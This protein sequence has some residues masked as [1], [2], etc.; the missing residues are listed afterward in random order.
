MRLSATSTPTPSKVASYWGEGIWDELAGRV[1]LDFGCRCGADAIEAARHGAAQ[2]IGLD[3]VPAALAAAANAAARAGVA[4]VCTFATTTDATADRILCIDAFE[5]FAD[6]AAILRTMDGLLRPGGVVLV[7]FG[8]PW[9]HP[10]GGHAFSVFPWA[11]L[12]FTERALCRWR[13]DY[14]D[15]GAT[16]FGE[17]EGGL[18]RMTICRF[19]RLVADSPFRLAA[20]EA[21]PI[22]PLRW[23]H[24]RL[25]REFFTS[26]VRCRLVRRS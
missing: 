18:N 4:D 5:H 7:T 13:G 15:D 16:R 23:L 25:S 20:F 21:V 24:N 14:R 22:R 19:R 12:L 2:V 26:M 8:P 9:L 11:H 17:V 1:V 3:I 10:Y 6:P